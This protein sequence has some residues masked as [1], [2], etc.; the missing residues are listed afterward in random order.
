[1]RA[2]L[3]IVLLV[4]A[5][6]PVWADHALIRFALADGAE[7]VKTSD[8]ATGPDTL[9]ALASIGKAFTAVA[10]LRLADRGLI[11]IDAPVTDYLSAA[12]TADVPALRGRT[13]RHLLTMTSGLSDY[14]TYSFFFAALAN[15]DTMLRPETALRTVAGDPALFPAG[16]DYDYSNTNYLI[17]GMI[18][19]EVTGDDYAAV[20]QREVLAP[21]GITQSFVSGSRPLPSGFAQGH[22]DRTLVRRYYAGQGFGDGGILGTAR[23]LARF[24]TALF[25]D[26]VLLS[27]TALE[28]MLTDAVGADYGMGVELT[29]GIVGHSGGDFGYSSDIRMNLATGAIAIELAASEGADIS[30]PWAIVS[31][32]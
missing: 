8:P 14:Y 30:W 26:R 2:A 9:F 24:Y 5:A 3:A 12:V 16:S 6:P 4:L 25:D 22:S 20:I 27:P 15:P 31:R 19:E 7:Y 17:L 23:D 13:P 32:D 28:A 11:D 1:M 18:L 21:A 10:I 29:D